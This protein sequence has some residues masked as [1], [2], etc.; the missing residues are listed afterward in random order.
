[1]TQY[2]PFSGITRHVTIRERLIVSLDF[3][4][5]R[6]ALHLVER[7]GRM[8]G[9][10]KVGRQLFI[11]GGPEFIRD[12]RRRGA[13]VFLDLK[14]HD[15]P[16]SLA[17]G[18]MEATRLGVRMFDVHLNGHADAVSRVRGEVN[19]VCHSEGLRR[20]TIIAVAMLHGVDRDAASPRPHRGIEY[21]V[22][23][24]KKAAGAGLDGVLTSKQGAMQVRAMC[25]RRFIIVT[26]GSSVRDDNGSIQMLDGAAAIRA[27][28]DYLVVGSAVWNAS[29]PAR[30]VR[31]IV[32]QI[33]R[34][35]R[36]PPSPP[37]LTITR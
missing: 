17:R 34:T 5:R 3:G 15:T 35:L 6:E 16:Q 28:A 26:S 1:M 32:E 36:N 20:P 8:V 27:G 10:F 4:N 33:E 22:E 25:G 11:S 19:R 29:E 23:L 18:A 7:L 37:H 2:W 30:A 31:E 9:M 24:A 14:F 21:V 13:D 12:I